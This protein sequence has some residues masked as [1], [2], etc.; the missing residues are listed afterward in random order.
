MALQSLHIH[1]NKSYELHIGLVP[2]PL[3]I[4]VEA[5]KK[6]E[7]LTYSLPSFLPPILL[8]RSSKGRSGRGRPGNEAR[9]H[10]ALRIIFLHDLD[11]ETKGIMVFRIP[12]AGKVLTARD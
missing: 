12:K 8:Q 4:F 9:S 2:L 5:E 7:T 3:R 1:K 6:E 11:T 10:G